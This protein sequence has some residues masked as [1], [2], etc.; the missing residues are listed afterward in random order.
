[1]LYHPF[2]ITQ[3]KKTSKSITVPVNS[4]TDPTGRDYLVTPNRKLNCFTT[5]AG[6]R[7]FL[8]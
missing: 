7:L 2:P 8:A 6:G 1:M 5:S 3:N 4:V